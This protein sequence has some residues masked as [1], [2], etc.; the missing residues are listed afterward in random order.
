MNVCRNAARKTKEKINE[1]EWDVESEEYFVANT[2]DL[3]PEVHSVSEKYCAKQIFAYM[4]VEGQ[5]VKFQLDSGATCN[6]IP[7]KCI[8]RSKH[9]SDKGYQLSMYNKCVLKPLHSTRLKMKI[10]G[11]IHCLTR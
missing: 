5:K 1:E 3:M 11:R 6:V 10:Q 7:A 4:V 2:V 9:I 8:N